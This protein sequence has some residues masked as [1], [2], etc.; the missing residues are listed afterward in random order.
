MLQLPPVSPT[1]REGREG[2]WGRGGRDEG[3]G[4][5]G[6]R[7]RREGREGGWAGREGGMTVIHILHTGMFNFFIETFYS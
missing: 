6:G 4:G 3:S 7:L 1:Y 2:G 5:E